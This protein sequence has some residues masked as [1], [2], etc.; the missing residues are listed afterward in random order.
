M[1][2]RFDKA[3]QR[4]IEG[5]VCPNRVTDVAVLE[6]MRRIPREKFLPE[7]LQGIAYI[8][9]DIALGNG[10]YLPEPMILARLLQAACVRKTDIALDIGCGTGYSS[11][12]LGG[13]C[14]HVTGLEQDQKMVSESFALLN[15]LG[16]SNVQIVQENHMQNGYTKKA[17]YDV[18][19]INGSAAAIPEKIKSQLA[20]GG[21][22]ASVVSDNGHMGVAVLITHHGGGFSTRKLFDAATPFLAGFEARKNFVF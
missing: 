8:D 2:E 17:P 11:A 15:R 5:Q 22:L 1:Q 6:V 13:L 10:R 12:V 14:S 9:E 18:I 4:M 19:L 3:R 7:P 16:I 21:R 20:E